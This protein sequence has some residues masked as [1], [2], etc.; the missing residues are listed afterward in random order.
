MAWQNHPNKVTTIMTNDTPLSDVLQKATNDG[1]SGAF[2]AVLATD[3]PTAS[4]EGPSA[5]DG[6][7]W[8]RRQVRRAMNRG[9]A[10]P[11]ET[12]GH[13][14]TALWDGR[15]AEA[16]ARADADNTALLQAAGLAPL[17]A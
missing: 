6:R 5:T 4:D 10:L 8:P 1:A 12:W 2:V 3:V 9:G 17:P 14:M 13:F 15:T 11:D 7:H 16:A